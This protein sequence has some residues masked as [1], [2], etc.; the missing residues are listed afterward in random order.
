MYLLNE[1]IIKNIIRKMFIYLCKIMFLTIF[2]NS[3]SKSPKSAVFELTA[4]S[5]LGGSLKT[6]LDPHKKIVNCG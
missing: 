4:N 5:R 2:V 1:Q 6:F 3:L